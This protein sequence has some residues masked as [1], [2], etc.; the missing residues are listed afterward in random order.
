MFICADRLVC[1]IDIDSSGQCERD[2]QRR[3]HQKV[4]F[5][6][7]VHARL[8]ISVSR[9]HR[10]RDQI[11]IV[12]RLL[13]LRM[14]RAGIADA[15]C[16]TVTDEVEPELI[17]IFLQSGFL[18]IIGN[19][20]RTGRERSFHRRIDMQPAL[21]RFFREQSRCQHH[22]WIA[23]VRA[24]G[25]RRDQHGAVTD[26]TLTVLEWVS[27]RS[28]Q[29]AS[30]VRRW[31]VRHHLDLVALIARLDALLFFVARSHLAVA[32]RRPIQLH[33]MFRAKIDIF[34]SVAAVRDRF[35][36]KRAKRFAKFRKIDPILR[37]FRPSHARLHIAEIQFEID[38]V[39][40]FAFARHPEH[41]L[42][43]KIIF[44]RRALLI[45]APG[46][47]QIIYRLLID[48]EISHRRAVLR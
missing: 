36:Q 21:D 32:W 23:R 15:G 6:V 8:K 24:T 14:Q 33:E 10:R 16:A 19:D 31:P 42:R 38:A 30:G 1:K 28:F 25:D 35:L 39:I 3:R 11:V 22:A 34:F 9:K 13:D 40:D 46:R 27:G 45:G 5:D 20:A 7:L 29:F 43:A 4:S 17:E 18:Q 26:F 48:R 12:D 44:K 41:F 47:S 2:H 37:S